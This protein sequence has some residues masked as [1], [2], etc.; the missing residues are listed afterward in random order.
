MP[1]TVYTKRVPKKP[2]REMM[3]TVY[4]IRKENSKPFSLFF[5]QALKNDLADGG[6][7]KTCSGNSSRSFPQKVARLPKTRGFATGM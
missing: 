3:K 1:G 6:D 4:H 2:K 7:R 5:T